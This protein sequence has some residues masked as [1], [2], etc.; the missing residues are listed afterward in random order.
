MS[1]KSNRKKCPT[2]RTHRLQKM[3]RCLTGLPTGKPHISSKYLTSPKVAKTAIPEEQGA[4]FYHC[5][6]EGAP[7]DEFGMNWENR[8]GRIESAYKERRA[9]GKCISDRA[10]VHRTTSTRWLETY[11]QEVARQ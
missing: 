5:T 7:A 1:N 11:R 9:P 6:D 2:P 3:Y 4:R 8:D 10:R